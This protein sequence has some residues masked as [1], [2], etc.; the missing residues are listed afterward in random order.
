MPEQNINDDI[1]DMLDYYNELPNTQSNS[2]EM[3]ML[4]HGV[5]W[6]DFL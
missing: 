4:D 2:L 6:S 3:E 1:E 5:S